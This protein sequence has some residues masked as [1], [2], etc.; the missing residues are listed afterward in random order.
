MKKNIKTIEKFLSHE[1]LNTRAILGGNGDD[2][3]DEGDPIIDP[4]TGGSL[5][6]S[7][8]RG[9]KSKEGGGGD[10]DGPTALASTTPGQWE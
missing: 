6:G 3:C 1:L 2:S 4:N 5:I 9:G 8:R 7:T 10:E